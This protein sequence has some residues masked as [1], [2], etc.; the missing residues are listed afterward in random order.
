[1]GVMRRLLLCALLIWPAVSSA[2]WDDNWNFRKPLTIDTTAAGAALASSVD[3]VTV[4]V[5]L[6]VARFSYFADTRADGSDIR[7]I[8][9]DDKTP[10]PFHIESYDPVAGMAFIW[11]Q[12]PRLTTGTSETIYMYYGNPSAPAGSDAA[13]SFD[14][15]Q[16]LVYHFAGGA[17]ADQTS[18]G[19]NPATSSAVANPASVIGAGVRFN[20]SEQIAIPATPSLRLIPSQ[21][22]T[23]S[24]W[25]NIDQEQ[26][27]AV[28]LQGTDAN[29]AALSLAI[30]GLTPYVQVTDGTTAAETPR[31]TRLTPGT[32]HLLTATVGSDVVMLYLDGAR[33]GETTAQL[34]EIGGS[35]SVGGDVAGQRFLFGRIDELTV[36][37]TVRSPDWITAQF[38]NQG[39]G[40]RLL[41]YGE[42]AARE[43]SGEQSYL[44]ITLQNVTV[45][46]WAII[47]V[48]TLMAMMSWVIM[49]SK[50]LIIRRV[51]RDNDAFIRKFRAQAS[52]D[53][54]S[55]DREEEDER[56]DNP[57]ALAMDSAEE[58]EYRQ[59]PNSTLYHLYHTGIQEVKRR[60]AGVPAGADR[61]KMLSRE[62]MDAIRATLDAANVRE[63]QRLNSQMVL[64]TLAIAG[65]PFLGLLGTV[66]GVMITFAAIAAT[67]DVNVNSIA[68]GIAAAL[69]A[70]VAGLGVAIP[71]LFGYNW[72]ASQIKETVADDR[73]FVD[74]FVTRLAEHYS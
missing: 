48:L 8:A 37:N 49:I 53:V 4:L 66:V 69:V 30:D 57:F 27:D 15:N 70:T 9:A 20:G 31:T 12:V 38:A 23:V 56:P 34:A 29:G 71:A 58:H 1:M 54:S 73:V 5:R 35:F 43:A 61:S 13:A 67:G 11:V 55:L 19:N 2:W 33:I 50:G 40:E 6:D 46:G 39:Q 18:Y 21:G 26:P 68:P 64:L 7:F 52:R 65:G 59:F 42:D 16:V 51:R 63:T 3:K 62:A 25:V 24:L 32:W 44:L 74:E 41:R 45:D 28:L 17:A 60:F 10:L 14:V 72:L 36:A 22:L 47:G